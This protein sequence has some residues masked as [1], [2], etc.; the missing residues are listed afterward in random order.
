MKNDPIYKYRSIISTMVAH[1]LK[2]INSSKNNKSFKNI[3]KYDENTL[4]HY[5]EK[6][7]DN[8]MNHTNHGKYWDVGHR[9]P[10]SWFKTKKDLIK[11]GWNIKNVFPVEKV[12]NQTIQRDKFAYI[13][14][15]EIYSKEEAIKELYGDEK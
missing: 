14:N 15:N 5:L 2:K 11:Y 7:F 8:K 10:L 4:K 6:Q 9:I 13:N 1:S 3:L 12:F